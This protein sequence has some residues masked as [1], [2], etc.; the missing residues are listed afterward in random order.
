[1]PFELTMRIPLFLNTNFTSVTSVENENIYFFQI[2]SVIT[3]IKIGSS[4]SKIEGGSSIGWLGLFE[5][6]SPI[7][8][9]FLTV[10]PV[11]AFLIQ[12]ISRYPV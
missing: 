12:N 9:V 2:K 8:L 5:F 1:M 3:V 6:M 10:E 4:S 11:R 7:S